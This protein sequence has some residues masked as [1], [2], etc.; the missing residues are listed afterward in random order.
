MSDGFAITAAWLS[1]CFVMKKN[2][3]HMPAA[4]LITMF[5]AC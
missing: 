2:S 4:S 3:R 5:A 1:H